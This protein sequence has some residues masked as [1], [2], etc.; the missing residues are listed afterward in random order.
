MKP[1]PIRAAGSE[2]I[3]LVFEPEFERVSES[4]NAERYMNVHQ[5]FGTYSGRVTS[6]DGA[7][8]EV[9]E[10][11]GWVEDQ[12]AL[13]IFAAQYQ[14]DVIGDHVRQSTRSVRLSFNMR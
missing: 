7:P 5:M 10:L 11:F 13:V 6:D 4:G 12:E 14:V 8:I 2:R 3:E 9:R 1:W